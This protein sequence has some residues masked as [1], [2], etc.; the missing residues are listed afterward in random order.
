MGAPDSPV[1]H[2]TVNVHCLMRATSA[3]PLGFGAVDLWRL[4]S[5]TAPDSPVAHQTLSGDLWL[6]CSDSTWHCSSPFIWAVDRWCVGSCCSAGSPDSLVNYSG[7]RLVNSR[8][9]LVQLRLGL[10]HRTLSSAPFFST[11]SSLAPNWF[12]SPTWILSWFI[13]NLMHLR[14][15][16]SRQTS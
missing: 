10:V 15:M 5:S 4:L 11:L 9:W 6:C 1:V 2:R 3:H 13:L 14:Y 16:I 8:E 7:A 12:E